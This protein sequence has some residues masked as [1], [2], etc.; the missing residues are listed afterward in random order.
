MLSKLRKQLSSKDG[1][2]IIENVLSLSSLQMVTMLLPVITLPYIL[3]TIGLTKYGIIAMANSLTGFFTS[4]TDYSFKL[5]ATRD[6][7]IHRHSIKKLNLIYSKVSL[8][9]FSLCMLSVLVCLLIIYMYPPFYQERLVFLLYIPMLI[10]YAIFPD[11]FFQG[12]EK[13]KYISLLNIGTKIFFTAFIFILIKSEK[14]YWIYPALQSAGFIFSGLIA[15]F[16]IRRLYKIKFSFLKPRLYLATLKTNFPVFINQFLPNLYNN[17]GILILGIFTNNFLVGVYDAIRKII[18]IAI[19]GI[20]I[21]SRVFFP[22]LNRNRNSFGSYKKIMLIIGAVLSILPIVFYKLIFLYLN[23]HY[24]GAFWVLLVLSIGIFGYTLYDIFGVNYFIINR[25]D[26]IVMH[27]TIVSSLIGFLLATPL[28]M[29][30]SIIGAAINLTIA[31]YL[32]GLGLYI[33]Y[34]RKNSSQTF[35]TFSKKSL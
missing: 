34:T 16:L 23:I 29:Y 18:D 12:V 14:D 32:M 7:A 20:S 9:R 6:V 17:A 28:I 19:T 30:A 8:I 1:R 4:V 13:M 3:H 33:R 21:L 25:Q 26:K 10:G 24:D 27:N 35:L 31:R 2:T 22:F 5:T 15:Q 11:W